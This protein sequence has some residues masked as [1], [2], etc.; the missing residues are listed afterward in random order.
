M[1]PR[2]ARG[3]KNKQNVYLPFSLFIFFFLKG[4]VE[5][6][7]SGCQGLL[8]NGGREVVFLFFFFFYKPFLPWN[9]LRCTLKVLFAMQRCGWSNQNKASFFPPRSL[10]MHLRVQPPYVENAQDSI[11]FCD[12]CEFCF[13]RAWLNIL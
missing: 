1:Y 13:L 7:L 12:G 2:T 8:E 5:F 6:V 11:M 10:L 3:I 4:S 9:E